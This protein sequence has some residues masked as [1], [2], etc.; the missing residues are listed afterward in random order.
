MNSAGKHAVV[1]L[2]AISLAGCTDK[3][4]QTV[5]PAQAQAP[6]LST[7]KAGTETGK[8]GAMY[9]PPLTQADTQPEQPSPAPPPVTAKVEP[10]PPPQPAPT[11][12]TKIATPHKPKPSASKPAADSD[13]SETSSAQSSAT[14]PAQSTDTPNNVA[15]AGAPAAASPI[16]QLS[17]GDPGQ[18]ETRK[19]TV[20]LITNTEN[21]LNSIKRSLT[22]QEQE[23]ATQIKTFILKAREA[24]KIDDVDGAHTLATK[25]KVLLDELTKT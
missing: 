1:A 16:G 5:Q 22:A 3:K 9:P 8:A 19:D 18:T 13:S 4:P 2:F 12:T 11:K 17:T 23:T 24:L 20:D 14:T 6:T 25:A 10:P 21:G 7:D 15:T